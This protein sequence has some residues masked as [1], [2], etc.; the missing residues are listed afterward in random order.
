MTHTPRKSSPPVD[1]A[2]ADSPDSRATSCATDTSS[3]SYTFVGTAG[4]RTPQLIAVIRTA[5]LFPAEIRIRKD[6]CTADGKSFLELLKLGV[7]FGDT[8]TIHTTGHA[9]SEALLA[10]AALPFFAPVA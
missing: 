8:L 2:P 9:A 7:R 5:S 10:V 6:A 3:C 4:W 1:A